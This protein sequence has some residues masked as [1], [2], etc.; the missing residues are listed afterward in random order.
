MAH[1]SDSLLQNNRLRRPRVDDQGF[2]PLNS[3]YQLGLAVF[4]VLL[5]AF[6]CITEVRGAFQRTRKTDAGVYFRAA[7][8]VRTGVDLYRIE[9]DNGW[10]YHYPALF[11]IVM[12]PF[13]DPPQGNDRSG[14]LPYP[15]ALGLWYV[16]CLVC[17]FGAVHLLA[18]ALEETSRDPR[19]RGLPRYC[20]RWWALRMLPIMICLL[21]IGRD[22]A[23]GQVGMPW[24]LLLCGTAAAML[25]GQKLR[26]GLWLA[27][28]ICLKII[29]ALLL[30]VPL[31]RRDWRMLSGCALGLV[32]GLIL[33]PTVVLGPRQTLYAY[34]S[35]V[36]EVLLPGL[37][38]DTGGSRGHELTG[39]AVNSSNSPRVVVHNILH[40]D[41]ATRPQEAG[42][43]ARLIHWLGAALL[44]AFTC[45]VGQRR[46]L[47][48]LSVPVGPSP[49][50]RPSLD[51]EPGPGP[52]LARGDRR[53]NAV[54]RQGVM[55]LAA[56][57]LVTLMVSPVYYP[58]YFS[59]AV[60]PVM[61]LLALSWE[62][63]GYPS[64]PRNYQWL[65]IGIILTHLLT[66]T[67][68]FWPL[69]DFGLV[70]F[71]TLWLWWACVRELQQI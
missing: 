5:V 41:R 6:G 34:Q 29:P 60:F 71:T 25:R 43:A 51:E 48:P 40:P 3:R 8:A 69:R 2:A 1:F 47:H 27:G 35:V 58:H 62:A 32:I 46:H 49:H 13:A 42:W 53:Q 22:L 23:R 20:E 38:A 18:G 54:D 16:T 26:S 50:A 24:L 39:I 68:G 28:A 11:A 45:I 36:S 63:H 64:C 61:L 55:L 31:L 37:E 59:I 7:W 30:L 57:S 4:A 56:L 70:L 65:F 33:I 15:V 9:D 14:M 52:G 21:P 17:L 10:H 12:T 19:V 67:P 44:I 66:V